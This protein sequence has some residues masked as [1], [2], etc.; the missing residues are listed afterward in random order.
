MASS[1]SHSEAQALCT[2]NVDVEGSLAQ[3][4][5]ACVL[6]TESEMG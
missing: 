1:K 5:S 3:V 4:D 2:R 6:S